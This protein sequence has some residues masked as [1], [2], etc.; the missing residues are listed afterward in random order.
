[1]RA[2]ELRIL[3]IIKWFQENED[4]KGVRYGILLNTILKKKLMSRQTYN[5][6]LKILVENGWVEKEEI[7]GERGNPC[8]YRLIKDLTKEQKEIKKTPLG[9]L[10]KK[11]DDF[12]KKHHNAEIENYIQA[13]ME[14][15]RALVHSRMLVNFSLNAN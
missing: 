2:R 15:A 13:M 7:I 4:S 11:I 3:E 5:R 6:K 14:L 10:D 9:K 8:L 12:E 1:M